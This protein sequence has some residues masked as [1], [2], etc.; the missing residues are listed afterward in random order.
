MAQRML[1]FAFGF[2]MTGASLAAAAAAWWSAAASRAIAEQS[3]AANRALAERLDRVVA[4]A[5]EQKSPDWVDFQVRLVQ[6]RPDGPP[7]RGVID[8]PKGD[9]QITPEALNLR[10][11]EPNH[12]SITLSE[13]LAERIRATLRDIQS[14]QLSARPDDGQEE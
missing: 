6:E 14:P 3:Q 11:G 13:K 12:F 5:Q 9:C 10:P 1:L 2:L 4:A 8:V 7:A